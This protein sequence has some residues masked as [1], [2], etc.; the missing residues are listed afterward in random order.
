MSK[1]NFATKNGQ[2][3]VKTI[4]RQKRIPSKY[5]FATTEPRQIKSEKTRQKRI[6][7]TRIE[8]RQKVRQNIIKICRQI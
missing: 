6:P 4:S 8:T 5:N 3:F 2:K 1:S 7:S